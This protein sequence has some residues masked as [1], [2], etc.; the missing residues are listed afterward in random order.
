MSYWCVGCTGFSKGV[1]KLCQSCWLK[2]Y[3]QKVGEMVSLSLPSGGVMNLYV[4][5]RYTGLVRQL[6]LSAKLSQDMQCMMTL[7]AVG[8]PDAM[9]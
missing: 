8:S 2:I 7:L 9:P 1:D 3:Q 4:L 5:F 6:L